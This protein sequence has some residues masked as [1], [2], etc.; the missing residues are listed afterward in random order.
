MAAAF[1]F[2]CFYKFS[3]NALK[4]IIGETMKTEQTETINICFV[5][6]NNYAKYMGL[7][8]MSILKSANKE[9]KLHFFVLDNQ[10]K[11]EEKDK[12]A[13]LKEI[14]DFK[15]TYIPISNNCHANQSDLTLTAYGC[16]L[17]PWLIE[18]EKII[19]LDCD[20]FVRRSLAPLFNID[21]SDYYMAGAVDFCMKKRYILSKFKNVILPSDYVNSGVLLINNKKWKEE[22]IAD[23]FF[24]YAGTH[25][26]DL[27]YGD[28]DCLNYFL[29]SKILKI[30]PTWNMRY[31]CYDPYIVNKQDNKAE[32]I[33]AQKDPAIRHFKPWKKN[34][35][36]EFREEYIEMMK[37]SPWAEFVPVDDLSF[38]NIIK[39]T[40]KYWL[41][42]PLCFLKPKFYTRIKHRGF[43]NTVFGGY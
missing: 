1:L 12:I 31:H 21:I 20:I 40:F 18:A 33:S 9:D 14:K 24:K 26:E 37:S 27:H 22:S 32:I 5:S 11:Q 38:T 43:K 10:I 6:D 7:A 30:N 36:S 41:R 8:L 35:I 4:F 23:A 19:Y 25:S 16:F 34:N 42:Y 13:S 3:K 2:G 17:V 39:T 29:Y 15:I 28:Q